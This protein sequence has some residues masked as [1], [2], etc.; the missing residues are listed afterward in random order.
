MGKSVRARESGRRGTPID[1]L[2]APRGVLAH[3]DGSVHQWV[4]IGDVP[5]SMMAR[6]VGALLLLCHI[7][8]ALGLT[9][10]WPRCS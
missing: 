7:A 2:C 9:I 1:K 8:C 10:V 6:V 3:H 4:S 5:V